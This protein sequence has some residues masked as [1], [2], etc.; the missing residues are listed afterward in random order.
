MVS[1]R[2]VTPQTCSATPTSSSSNA[3][4]P[5]SP[6]ISS[7]F[8]SRR[9][10]TRS[11][12]TATAAI[13][14]AATTTA[15][16]S[17]QPPEP[18]PNQPAADTATNAPSMKNPPWA[19]LRM[20]ITPKMRVRPLAMRNSGTPVESPDSRALRNCPIGLLL[21]GPRGVPAPAAGAAPAAAA[22]QRRPGSGD[23]PGRSGTGTG[24]LVVVRDRVVLGDLQALWRRLVADR[25]EHDHVVL[26]LVGVRVDGELT[27]R[28]ADGQPGQRPVDLVDV[29]ATGLLDR[30]GEHLDA[31]VA[32]PRPGRRRPAVG[33]LLVRLH[34]LRVLRRVRRAV[35]VVV[36][37]PDRRGGAAE[38][39]G[40][41]RVPAGSRDRSVLRGQAQRCRLLEERGG[42]G[43]VGGQPQ[44]PVRIL[45]LGQRP[46][47]R[48]DLRPVVDRGQRHPLLLFLLQLDVVRTHLLDEQVVELVPDH[49]V[50]A[51]RVD[52]LQGR[53]LLGDDL[54][55]GRGHLRVVRCHAVEVLRLA[56]GAD[57]SVG[58]AGGADEHAL[59]LVDD[60][61]DGQAHRAGQ[62]AD[63]DLLPGRDRLAGELRAG[64]RVELV[65][66]DL[67]GQLGAA[68]A[69]GG[70]DLVQRDL[71]AVA[72]VHA[73][74]RQRPGQRR[75]ERERVRPAAPATATA[76]VVATTGG[77][78]EHGGGRGGEQD[79]APA[80][81]PPDCGHRRLL[82]SSSRRGSIRRSAPRIR[83]SISAGP[84][85]GGGIAPASGGCQGSS[86]RSVARLRTSASAPSSARVG[87]ISGSPPR[88]CRSSAS[89]G[90]SQR[91]ADASVRARTGRWPAG[92]AATK[93]Y[94]SKRRAGTQAG[95]IQRDHGT[96]NR[97]SSR[98]R[99][100]CRT[101]A[102]RRVP[103]RS[104]VRSRTRRPAGSAGT[105]SDGS[106]ASSTAV[107][108]NTSR[109]AA[110]ST[111]STSIVDR[112]V[113][114]Q[115][116]RS[117]VAGVVGDA[118]VA[119]SGSTDPP[120]T[121]Q[122]PGANVIVGGRRIRY[123]SG[124]P[125]ASRTRATV[126]AR[127]GTTGSRGAPR[128]LPA[129]L[130]AAIAISSGSNVTYKRS[131]VTLT[132]GPQHVN[133]YGQGRRGTS[134]ARRGSP[135]RPR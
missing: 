81:P 54:R 130:E 44:H 29:R 98:S 120:G 32:L 64:G 129:S 68:G 96:S 65:V 89:A 122:T 91:A 84:P 115:A 9:N 78:R 70:V 123:T 131:L 75:E 56:V 18:P 95:V 39:P 127:R 11:Q 116:L 36:G 109:T 82:P 21:R 114:A 80:G 99:C 51:E 48:R 15:P 113:G 38:L 74:L 135:R 35:L 117:V 3:N 8:C 42:S 25:L 106:V 58:R 26:A 67:H 69:T 59:E 110:A 10:T 133:G 103:A 55:D 87:I 121:T 34:E 52:R 43:T 33:E 97:A 128:S 13:A 118:V 62:H 47:H 107:S 53:I 88:A 92:S 31:H 134:G 76:A 85:G 23:R 125:V 5:S 50:V 102:S 111:R 90:R 108:S 16:N 46:G 7:R 124:P 71:R 94:V 28:A 86:A 19:K 60:R 57:Q 30:A 104:A 61:R 93:K 40:T 41:R 79:S 22:R 37:V 27:G 105:R 24:D 2:G 77:R 20:P 6:M 83:R 101:S 1:D 100:S 72:H 12:T 126:A 66:V 45:R 119:S 17:V 63:D 73:G 4:V 132:C 14:T 112:P 49:V